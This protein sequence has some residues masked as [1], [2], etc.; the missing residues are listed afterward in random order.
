MKTV[1]IY[2]GEGLLLVL[3]FVW[4]IVHAEPMDLV[5]AAKKQDFD[6]VRSLLTEEININEA[7]G[8]GTTAL[9]WTVYWDD[10]DTAKRLVDEGA[11]VNLANYLGVSPLILAAR[12]QSPEMMAALLEVGA[13]PNQATW[14]G[15]TVLM[16]TARTGGTKNITLL[17]DHGAEINM[18]E[19]RRGQTALMWAISYGHPDVARVLIERGADINS[20]TT[21]LVDTEDYSP[22]L[23]EGFG[24]N[25]SAIA[26]GGYTALMFA[27]RQG[28]IASASL[29]LDR[30]A[31]I[32][33]VSV[34]DGS[35]L[36]I[37][38]AW[39]HDDLAM[40]LL[41]RG[42]D[43]NI[44]DAN[45]MTALHFTMRDGLKVLLGLNLV[46]EKQ[47]CGFTAG[48][49][50]KDMA[51]LTDAELAMIDDPAFNL[52]IIEGK[53]KQI[54]YQGYNRK[55]L[56]GDTMHEL[57]EALLARGADVNAAMKYPPPHMRIEHL[58]WIN[59]ANSS[60]LFLAAAAQDQFAVEI[61]LEHGADLNVTTD[62]NHE[63]FTDQISKHD[64][65]NQIQGNASV[66]MAA[67]GMGRQKG[68]TI[69]QER[70]ALAI[71]KRLVALGADVNEA[72]AAG[73][74]P[75][76]VAA[77]NGTN[78]LVKFLVEQGARL[79]VMN[80]CGRTPLSLASG[81][82]TVGLLAASKPKPDTVKLLL[83]LGS[84]SS[85]LTGPVGECVLGRIQDVVKAE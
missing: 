30:G 45:G 81:E 80:G 36:V 72:N 10:L 56:P 26:K 3:L 1:G 66:F 46:K 28:D 24:G 15:E 70:T 68:L 41:E 37:A 71:T 54:D 74:T 84:E 39:G 52:K 9:A 73:W 35:A 7:Q 53:T 63:V 4:G 17:L 78:T 27:A 2:K 59:L 51:I 18:Q 34:E 43:P 33:A 13:D 6:T 55:M 79:N 47:V 23:M 22:M 58:T 48:V 44:E 62:I 67:V 65:G 5:N 32:D 69:E 64:D 82:N 11:D 61:M 29:I 57:A 12:N 42:A 16:S 85:E 38:V 21:Q 14:S 75:L 8:D 25:V 31:E 49:P 60:P 50:C 19:P 20:R 76:H 77:F 83:A 40:A